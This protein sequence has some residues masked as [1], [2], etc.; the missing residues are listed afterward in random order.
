MEHQVL[1]DLAAM[2]NNKA[3]LMQKYSDEMAAIVKVHGGN[4]SDVPMNPDSEYH[5]L[6]HKLTILGRLKG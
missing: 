3:K 6:Q 2:G 4:V 1:L 5:K